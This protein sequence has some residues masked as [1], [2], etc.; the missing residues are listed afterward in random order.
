M[1]DNDGT[2]EARLAYARAWT[3]GSP[4]YERMGIV[5][6]DLSDGRA[7]LRLTVAGHHLNA[8]GIVHGGVLPALADAAMGS[9]ARTLHGAAAQL[10]TIESNL[11]YFRPALPGGDIVAD[12]RVMKPGRRV[13][14]MDVEITDEAGAILARGGGSF[15]IQWRD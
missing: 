3:G 7:R 5:V 6:S 4:Y 8:D 12:A 11:R 1:T 13:A 9:A 2:L 10:L 14:V 15:L